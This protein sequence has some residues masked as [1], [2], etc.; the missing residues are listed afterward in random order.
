MWVTFNPAVIV[1]ALF[2][3]VALGIAFRFTS[4]LIVDKERP[5]MRPIPRRDISARRSRRIS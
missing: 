4:R 1:P 5:I 2:D 3:Y